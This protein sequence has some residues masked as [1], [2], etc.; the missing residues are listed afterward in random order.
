[1]DDLD[2]PDSESVGWRGGREHEG[3]KNHVMADLQSSDS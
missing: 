2:L 1:M 3:Q